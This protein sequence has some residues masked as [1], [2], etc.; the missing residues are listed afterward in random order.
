MPIKAKQQIA[1]ACIHVYV[2]RGVTGMRPKS[3]LK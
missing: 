2:L 1:N 3:V